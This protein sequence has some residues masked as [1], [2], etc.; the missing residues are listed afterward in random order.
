MILAEIYDWFTESFDTASLILAH[1]CARSGVKL[2][3]GAL[4]DWR[5]RE[6]DFPSRSA[7]K[8]SDNLVSSIMVSRN[9]SAHCIGGSKFRHLGVHCSQSSAR[10]PRR[11][12]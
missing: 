11:C 2:T 12:W 8:S 9:K 6:G 1:L 4:S 5:E 3:H 10:L 7:L